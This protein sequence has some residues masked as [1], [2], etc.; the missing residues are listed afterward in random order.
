MVVLR[1]KVSCFCLIHSELSLLLRCRKT[2]L[3]CQ[4]M[5]LLDGDQ[6]K[7]QPRYPIQTQV[8]VALPNA[9]MEKQVNILL[10][11]TGWI[12][13]TLVWRN[14]THKDLVCN[15]SY[16]LSNLWN[17]LGRYWN[18]GGDVIRVPHVK[19]CLLCVIE[20]KLNQRFR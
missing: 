5:D 6:I 7:A 9:S 10:L 15:G 12:K 20:I 16:S 18:R 14:T 4:I 11:E 17:H 13:P 2:L 19:G 3:W 8:R 1:C